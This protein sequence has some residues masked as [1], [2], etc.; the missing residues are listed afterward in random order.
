MHKIEEER[1]KFK[2][3]V[4]END[5]QAVEKEKKLN[6]EIDELRERLKKVCYTIC[7]I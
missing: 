3:I 5:R 1:E 7:F 6:S 4:E 2:R